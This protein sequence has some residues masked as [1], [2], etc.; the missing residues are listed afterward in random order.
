MDIALVH[1]I[2]QIVFG[3]QV[4]RSFYF[5]RAIFVIAKPIHEVYSCMGN[6]LKLPIIPELIGWRYPHSNSQLVHIQ[7]VVMVC[8]GFFCLV[9]PCLV[10]P[11]L[12][13][14]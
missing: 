9:H 13:H 5:I 6:A 8:R 12:V 10:H 4:E 11:C 14:P 7:Q 2:L 1:K 3:T